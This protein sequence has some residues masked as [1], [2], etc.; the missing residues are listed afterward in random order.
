MHRSIDDSGVL[1][2]RS[3]ETVEVPAK[4]AVRFEPGGFHIMVTDLQQPLLT[5]DGITLTLGF[6]RSGSVQIRVPIVG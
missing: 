3:V 2:M 4:G 6:D 1:R 5:G